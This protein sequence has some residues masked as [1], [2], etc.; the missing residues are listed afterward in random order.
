M[1]MEVMWPGSFH[2]GGQGHIFTF[3]P[4]AFL[5]I[6]KG[7]DVALHAIQGA[8]LIFLEGLYIHSR[9]DLYVGVTLLL[10]FSGYNYVGILFS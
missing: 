9:N 10:L 2:P 1:A 7:N 8:Y 5:K 4:D 3:L 6:A